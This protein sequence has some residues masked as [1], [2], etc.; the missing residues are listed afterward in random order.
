MRLTP[1]QRKA[2]E[3]QAEQWREHHQFALK[4][5]AGR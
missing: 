3:Q 4:S 1:A 5:V 2:I